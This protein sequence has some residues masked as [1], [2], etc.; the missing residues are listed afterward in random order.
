METE[1]FVWTDS[2][3]KEFVN[4]LYIDTIASEKE[5]EDFK[6]A[7][8]P[9][10]G[11]EVLDMVCN[12]GVISSYEN[13]MNTYPNKELWVKYFLESNIGW[14]IHSV[15]RLVDNEVFT[16]G[17]K[18]LLSENSPVS[19][20]ITKF[21]QDGGA[22]LAT[23]HG[24]ENNNYNLN[25]VYKAK[26]RQPLFTTEDN[27]EIYEGDAIWSVD[28]DFVII[29]MYPIYKNTYHTEIKYFKNINAAEK[30][31]LMNK[32]CLSFNDIMSISDAT[33]GFLRVHEKALNKVVNE[34]I[35]GQ[36]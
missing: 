35:N 7:K 21:E 31:V 17:D 26:V 15:K 11:Y 6:K 33:F 25:L 18:V 27:V 8:L 4:T 29:G 13:S 12:N 34:K 5:I 30:Y 23:I 2:L 10:L 24:L 9:K 1:N 3:V 28:I 36:N 22:I 19:S 14:Q 32:P 20:S 16:I